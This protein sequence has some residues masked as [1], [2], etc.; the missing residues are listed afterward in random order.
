MGP[1]CDPARRLRPGRLPVR[2]VDGEALGRIVLAD[3]ESV[4]LGSLAAEDSAGVRTETGVTGEGADDPL[5]AVVER[6]FGWQRDGP[7][8][9]VLDEGPR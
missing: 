9:T 6:L 5:V 7:T 1:S 4:V 8:G 2:A 3:R